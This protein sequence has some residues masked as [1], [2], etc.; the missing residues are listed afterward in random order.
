MCGFRKLEYESV[1]RL[2]HGMSSGENRKELVGTLPLVTF[3]EDFASSC[4]AL[5]TS[6]D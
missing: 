3:L 5:E 1:S 6:E 4:L 2:V